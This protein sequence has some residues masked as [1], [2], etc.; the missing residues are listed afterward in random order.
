MLVFRFRGFGAG[1]AV[2]SGVAV[3]LDRSPPWRSPAAPPRCGGRWRVLRACA[4]CRTTRRKYE[5]HPLH[6]T[7]TFAAG[8]GGDSA[9]NLTP[10]VAVVITRA[11]YRTASSAS[12]THCGHRGRSGTAADSTD[13]A[14]VEHTVGISGR[15]GATLAHRSVFWSNRWGF[16]WNASLDRVRPDPSAKQIGLNPTER[17]LEV[18]V[19]PD[20]GGAGET[21]RPAVGGIRS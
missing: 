12:L 6:F 4:G 5:P 2:G 16:L 10:A 3:Q 13:I 15:S 14:F 8:P 9:L 20:Y 7:L 18:P 19:A 17:A 1:G 11:G 21:S